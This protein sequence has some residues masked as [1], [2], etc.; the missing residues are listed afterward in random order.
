[1]KTRVS[2]SMVLLV[3]AILTALPAWAGQSSLPTCPAKAEAA[4]A[5]PDIFAS[6]NNTSSWCAIW[7][8]SPPYSM[9]WFITCEATY[10][11]T[12]F[13]RCVSGEAMSCEQCEDAYDNGGPSCLY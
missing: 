7:C 12:T 3:L 8:P 2:I 1:M 11:G 9:N 13:M 10:C 6:A 5:L 4:V